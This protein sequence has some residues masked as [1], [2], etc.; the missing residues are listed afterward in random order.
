MESTI[1]TVD[2]LDHDTIAALVEGSLDPAQRAQV[3]PHLAAC[4][5][6]RATVASVGCAL[7][8]RKVSAAVSAVEGR[9]WRRWARVAVPVAAAAAVLVFVALPSPAGD[10]EPVHRAA[11][12]TAAP[13][14]AAVAPVGA[15]APTR[16]LEWEP[17]SGADRYRVTLFGSEGE[18]LY[19][20]ELAGTV[21]QLPDTVELVPGERYWWRV[22]ARTGFDRWAASDLIEFTIAQQPRR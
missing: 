5:T 3:L 14:P 4:A 22:E 1:V 19:E 15:V 6:C 18:V 16:R 10:V 20:A 2:H 21:A 7:A 9:G 11:P 8:D 13:A 12:I 17:V